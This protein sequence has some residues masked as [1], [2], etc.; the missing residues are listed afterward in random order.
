VNLFLLEQKRRFWDSGWYAASRDAQIEL[1]HPA[2]LIYNPIK[3]FF[4]DP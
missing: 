1:D 3:K 2:K 4:S